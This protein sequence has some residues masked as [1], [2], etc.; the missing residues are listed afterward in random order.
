VLGPVI[1]TPAVLLG[2][3]EGHKAG[4]GDAIYLEGVSFS[5]WRDPSESQRGLGADSK[6]HGRA[7]DAPPT[8]V[9]LMP[10][11]WCVT[12]SGNV[13]PQGY[14]LTR[15]TPGWWNHDPFGVP[16]SS[17]TGP[18]ATLALLSRY[19]YHTPQFW[20]ELADDNK[21]SGGGANTPLIKFQRFARIPR[22]GV[23][24]KIPEITGTFRSHATP[25]R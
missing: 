25:L 12:S 18:Y 1:S 6:H 19:F 2:F 4:E 10:G 22:N 3:T 15:G 17:T 7:S 23:K 21:L 14:G 9:T 11:G 8:S 13:I 20:R 5:E 16:P 24:I